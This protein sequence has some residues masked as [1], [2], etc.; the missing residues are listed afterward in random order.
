MLIEL[1]QYR[2]HPGQRDNWVRFMNEVIVPFQKSKGMKV[3]GMWV[4]EE[5]PDLFVWMREFENQEE[6][7][8]QYEAVYQSD[9]WKTEVA[10]KAATMNNREKMVITRL[11]PATEVPAGTAT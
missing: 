11:V 5:D 2:M 10:P 9:F 7:E 1:R 4:A 8:R 3:L 6:L